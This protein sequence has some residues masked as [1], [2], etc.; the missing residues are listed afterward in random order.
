ML[1]KFFKRFG[2]MGVAVL[3]PTS[4]YMKSAIAE[5][6]AIP[7][8]DPGGRPA[9]TI[10]SMGNADLVTEHGSGGIT[11][12]PRLP[13]KEGRAELRE[14]RK[15][16]RENHRE[17]MDKH[18]EERLKKRHEELEK[19]QQRLELKLEERRKKL[20]ERHK[21]MAQRQQ[22]AGTADKSSA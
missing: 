4:L 14:E 13:R 18:L 12:M 21:R 22:E 8:F 5:V 17:D 2:I 20:E 16:K 19:R 6:P 10:P 7:P 15:Q 11:P 3:V 9:D 1:K